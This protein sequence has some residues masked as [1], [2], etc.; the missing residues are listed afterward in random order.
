[1]R[2]TI[3]VCI[4]LL[5]FALLFVSCDLFS[6]NNTPTPTPAPNPVPQSVTLSYNSLQTTPHNGG[7]YYPIQSGT[8][9]VIITDLP[10][11][12]SVNLVR[13]NTTKNDMSGLATVAANEYSGTSHSAL[14]NYK[15]ELACIENDPASYNSAGFA[16]TSDRPFEIPFID[17]TD[18]AKL[19]R[20]YKEKYS[21]RIVEPDRMIAGGQSFS[22]GVTKTFKVDDVASGIPAT[23]SYEGRHCY[24]WVSNGEGKYANYDSTVYGES[25]TIPN[26]DNKITPD[27]AKD[28]GDAFDSLYEIETALIGNS[29]TTNPDSTYFIN[30]QAKVSILVYDIEGDYTNTQSGGTFGMFWGGDLYK[31]SVQQGSNEM[32][33]LYVDSYFTDIVF[34]SVISTVAHEFEH[35]LYFV[36]KWMGQRVTTGETWYTEM[37]AMM[38]EDCLA[39][40]LNNQYQNFVISRDSTLGRLDYFNLLYFSGGL[41]YW[42]SGNAVLTS[43]AISGIFGCWLQRNYGGK[44]LIRYLV[45]NDASNEASI[46]KAINSCGSRDTFKDAFRKF[47]LSFTQPDAT[48]F[49][50]NKARAGNAN[51]N[52]ELVAANPW[53]ETYKNT[54]EGEDLYGPLYVPGD[55]TGVMRGYGFWLTGWNSS[56]C[57]GVKLTFSS[58]TGEENYIVITE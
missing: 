9:E 4:S 15:T 38:A 35:M 33:L 3:K 48:A 12:N 46:T 23:L 37:G 24:V 41:G 49:T 27:Q 21:S 25:E 51:G 13:I 58:V 28:L 1:M 55:Y 40:Y 22:E 11:G 6:N 8:T 5:I 14:D 47:A 7:K 53:S 31:T 26:D 16:G 17:N 19:E 50:L 56:Q 30:P 32:E 45:N 29:Y 57:T 42:G 52:Y 39:T 18:Y 34:T 43:Y 20:E 10:Q 54:I 44:D 2:T 36:N